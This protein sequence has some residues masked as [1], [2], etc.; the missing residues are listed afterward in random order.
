MYTKC[1]FDKLDD[2]AT[3]LRTEGG[4]PQAWCAYNV[5]Q[6]PN[7]VMKKWDFCEK[8]CSLKTIPWWIVVLAI[9]VLVL[10]ALVSCLADYGGYMNSC[11]KLITD[12]LDGR[13]HR[14]RTTQTIHF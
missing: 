9:A 5:T 12:K 1:T 8:H 7:N 4:K 6:S 3:A 10:F 13:R 14:R 2:E 11:R